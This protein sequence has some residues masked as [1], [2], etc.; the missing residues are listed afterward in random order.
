[1]GGMGGKNRAKMRKRPIFPGLRRGISPIGP[2]NI[3]TLLLHFSDDQIS[4]LIPKIGN[5]IEKA[6]LLDQFHTVP[7]TFTQVS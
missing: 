6:V 4:R 3:R 5:K 7:S 2:W 1:M